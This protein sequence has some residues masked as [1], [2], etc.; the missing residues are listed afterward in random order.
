MTLNIA[1]LALT[2]LFYF[3]HMGVLTPYLGVF[4]DGRGLSSEAIGQLM[5]IMTIARLVAPNLW[6]WVADKT[7]Q[8]LAIIR[9]G[10]T[11]ALASFL[12]LFFVDGFWPIAICMAFSFGFWTSVI[13]QLE[14]IT[15]NEVEGDPARYSR[16]RM[17]GSIGFILMS[18]TGGA[19]I[20]VYGSEVILICCSVMLSCLLMSSFLLRSQA[21]RREDD[22]VSGSIW[23]KALSRPFLVFISVMSLL[24]MSF[25]AY[26]GFFALYMRDLGY[27]GEQTGWF[28][29]L[30]VIAEIGIFLIAGKLLQRVGIKRALML[31]MFATS[32]RWLM[33]AQWADMLLLILLS[34]CIHALSFG[35]AHA[36]AMQFVH[37]HFGKQFQNQGQ[38]LY[39]SLS[40]GLGG[41]IGSFV[42]GQLWL[43]GAGAY[44]TWCVAAGMAFVGAL[45]VNGL[46]APQDVS[47]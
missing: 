36:T 8:G 20:D 17:W 22:E 27:T 33:L 4:L 45:I 10:C 39:V 23:Q 41:S 35:F 40:F 6:A 37:K 13:P 44:Q 46:K 47:S 14:P 1:L 38:A 31:C 24:Q 11:L 26:Y 2:Y 15:L 43:Q 16:V 18:I 34:Q 29:S 21:V 30:G 7:G 32:F 9:I 12:I 25:G 42:A 5:A 3:G 19:L 28:I